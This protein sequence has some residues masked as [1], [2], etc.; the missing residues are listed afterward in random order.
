MFPWLTDVMPLIINEGSNRNRIPRQNKENIY[1]QF[2]GI[3]RGK[4]LTQW[5]NT[6]W[7][8]TER[9]DPLAMTANRKLPWRAPAPPYIE[10]GGGAYALSMGRG[11]HMRGPIPWQDRIFLSLIAFLSMLLAVWLCPVTG[12]KH[13]TPHSQLC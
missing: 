3:T 1:K 7:C 13:P 10:A 4:T 12:L 11:K 8:N 2:V 6:G 5:S 9:I